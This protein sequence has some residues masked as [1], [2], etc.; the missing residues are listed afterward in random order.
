MLKFRSSGESNNPEKQLDCTYTLSITASD[1]ILLVLTRYDY[2]EKRKGSGV[3]KFVLTNSSS[4]FPNACEV[5]ADT[6]LEYINSV[7]EGD[8][9]IID[10]LD[11][12]VSCRW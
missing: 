9:D 2:S 8:M 4:Q 3:E 11:S 7:F 10:F 5:S 6:T 1:A 12:I